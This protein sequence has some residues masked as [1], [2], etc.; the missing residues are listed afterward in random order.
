MICHVL[1]WS[2]YQHWPTVG[3]KYTSARVNESSDAETTSISILATVMQVF[4]VPPILGTAMHM[5]QHVPW[6]PSHIYSSPNMQKSCFVLLAIT[7]SFIDGC[8]GSYPNTFWSWHRRIPHK[9]EGCQKWWGKNP[10]T[11]SP[12]SFICG[13]HNNR[14]HSG[15]LSLNM[16]TSCALQRGSIEDIMWFFSIPFLFEFFLPASL[17][18][19]AVTMD[20]LVGDKF[21]LC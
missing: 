11:A 9:D 14:G 21:Q 2:S 13:G 19:R 20:F 16:Y 5:E 12:A 18:Y 3:F 10:A 4:P 8:D 6:E 1:L 17:H 15:T 7:F